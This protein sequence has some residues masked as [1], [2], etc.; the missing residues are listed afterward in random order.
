MVK[1]L[2]SAQRHPAKTPQATRWGTCRTSAPTSE[3][4]RINAGKLQRETKAP[5]T[6][7]KEITKGET[8]TDTNLVGASAAASHSAAA[9]PQNIPSA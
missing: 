6:I 7:M 2:P 1:V 8:A 9:K 5:N 4:P 3:D